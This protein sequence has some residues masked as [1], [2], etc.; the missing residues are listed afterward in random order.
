MPPRI[1][2]EQKIDMFECGNPFLQ[3]DLGG[4][5]G[6]R[7]GASGND[8]LQPEWSIVFIAVSSLYGGVDTAE[9]ALC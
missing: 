4:T 2:K 8:K 5:V 6:D 1:K 3:K 7:V 9:I